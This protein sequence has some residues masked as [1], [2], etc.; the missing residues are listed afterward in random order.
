MRHRVSVRLFL[1]PRIVA[2]FLPAVLVLAL[3]PAARAEFPYPALP[4]WESA[5]NAHV[6]TGGAWADVDDDG[7]L[8]MVV[9]NGNDISIQR[10]VVYHN[11][12]DGTFPDDPTW[13]SADTGYHGH[14]DVGD[15]D[16]DG[17]VDVAVSVYIGDAGFSAPG[18]AKIYLNDGVGGFGTTPVWESGSD[19]YTF[20]LALG[21][22]DGDGDLDLACAC[23]ESYYSNPEPQRIFYNTDGVFETSPSWQ[24]T[25]IGY[26]YDA[27]WDDCDLD[28][29]LDLAFCGEVN[30]LRVYLNGQTTGGG[31]ATT[32]SWENT[33][34]PQYGNT[35]AFGDWNDDGY[36]ELAVADNS[37]LGGFG[38]FKVYAN[39]AGTL[40]TAPAW[41]SGTGGYGSHVSWIDADT[42][43]DLDLAAGRWWGN[44][45]LFENT[46]GTFD[47]S[48]AWTSVG[49][50]VIENVFWG[51]VD[52]DGLRTNG[53]MSATGDGI[54]T[55]YRLG[56]T[57][58]RSVDEVRVDGAPLAAG[59]WTA[60]P[61]YGWI[62]L[63]S[64]PSPG[65][66]IEAD[67]TYSLDLDI[68]VT[69]W[70]TA[71]G[72]YLFLNTRS[73]VGVREVA[74]A[75]SPLRA[76]PNPVSAYTSIRHQGAGAEHATVA[77]YNLAGQLVRTL[78]DG[79]VGD[80]I[81][82][83]EWNATDDAGRRVAHGVYFVRLVTGAA[84][85]TLKLTV[86]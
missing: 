16:A 58:V 20:S 14:L 21:D 48:P 3:S 35:C 43:G 26:A 37:Q 12:G 49:R 22:A 70:D 34:L 23:G 67:F 79:P 5:P 25:E 86:L 17:L 61:T 51:D 27:F 2:P 38:Y 55:Y 81:R 40:G 6:A 29:D 57:P 85:R 41:T 8:D 72:N 62:S 13:S 74:E 59:E 83:W 46:G 30:P 69:N 9:A 56:Q 71:K 18:R 50:S 11:Q 47:V 31:I 42:D 80:G 36:P 28:G 73:P 24:S 53:L 19:F 76:S 65:A 78:H 77:V 39:T 32:A 44:L 64:P 33:D 1:S 10:V 60:H 52:N 75:I 7:W 63:A 15:L 82:V 66:S 84:V 54:R 68:G 45:K 4:S